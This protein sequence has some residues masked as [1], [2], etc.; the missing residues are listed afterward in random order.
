MI[1]LYLLNLDLLNIIIDYIIFKPS[2]RNE[3]NN[4]IEIWCNN[5]NY[6]L[7]CYGHISNWNICLI[8]DLSY[9][10]F[11]NYYFND[12]IKINERKFTRMLQSVE[13]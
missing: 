8:N 12:N 2:N 4:T 9:L 10:F 13:S 3:L 6:A 7:I 5:K 11:R 1:N